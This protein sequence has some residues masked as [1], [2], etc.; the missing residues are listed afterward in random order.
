M[1]CCEKKKTPR[2]ALSTW[3]VAQEPIELFDKTATAKN[4]GLQLFVPGDLLIDD[5]DNRDQTT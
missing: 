4:R 2:L 1:L 5:G 3:S